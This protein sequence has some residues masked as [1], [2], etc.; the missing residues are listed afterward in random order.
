MAEE[1]GIPVSYRPEDTSYAQLSANLSAV[2]D[3]GLLR[4]HREAH[5]RFYFRPRQAFRIARTMPRKW[6]LFR[7]ARYH[8]RLKFA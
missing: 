6:D 3:A 5:R 1:M 4:L 2:D 7:L 8:Y